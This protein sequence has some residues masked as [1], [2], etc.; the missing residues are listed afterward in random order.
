MVIPPKTRLFG[1]FGKI[2]R[3]VLSARLTDLVAALH[4]RFAREWVVDPRR[5]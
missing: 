2:R 3:A 1:H 5:V 4:E